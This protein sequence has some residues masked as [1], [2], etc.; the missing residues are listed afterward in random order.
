MRAP[1]APLLTPTT[2][3]ASKSKG[4]L[5]HQQPALLLNP[6]DSRSTTA[7]QPAGQPASQ[8]ASGPRTCAGLL[9]GVLAL[10]VPE[11]PLVVLD[12]VGRAALPER[13]LDPLRALQ[14]AS[15]TNPTNCQ[16][17]WPRTAT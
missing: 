10:V 8:P 13:V 6:E 2:G 17:G 11:A 3:L 5:P 15:V 14:F 16:N 9:V 1:G 4:W 12:Q 7:S